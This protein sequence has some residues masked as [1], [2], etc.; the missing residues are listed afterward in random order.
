MAAISGFACLAPVLAALEAGKIVALANK[1]SL[2][3]A[4]H[5]VMRYREQIIPVDSEQSSIFQYLVT[6]EPET[7]TLTA[8]GGPFLRTPLAEFS[9][10]TP[11]EAVRH[12]RWNM[13][14]KIS[15]DSATLMNKGLEVIEAAHLFALPGEKIRVV[16]H[17]QSIV[18][19][20]VE[21]TDGTQFACLFSTDMRAPI[22]YALGR[23][24]GRGRLERNNVKRLKLGSPETQTLEFFPPDLDR[25]PALRLCYE[26]LEA[27][28]GAPVVLN[29]ANEV[30]VQAFIEGRI[31]FTRIAHVVE[32]AL[33]CHSGESAGTIEEIGLLD[34][35]ARKSALKL[36]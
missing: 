6:G 8:S 2:V 18:H 36:L 34:A 23:A 31:G 19:G 26:A 35:I 21:C 12:P 27:G 15:V 13:G 11:A 5:L 17:P 16:I 9:R 28:G 1:E 4:G 3:A 10:V 20:I 7:I 24:S 32:R 22:A 33:I 14:A 29:A 25:F 30:A